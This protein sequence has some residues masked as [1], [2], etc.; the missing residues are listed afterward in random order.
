MFTWLGLI[1]LA[2]GGSAFGI[3]DQGPVVRL[4]NADFIGSINGSLSSFL[5]IPYAQPPTGSRRFRLP[6]PNDPY[7]GTFNVTSYGP[8]CPQQAS[9]FVPPDGLNPQAL[10]L[11][12]SLRVGDNGPMREDC[13]T[14]NVIKPANATSEAK[15]PVV[16]VSCMS[17]TAS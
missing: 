4:D 7:N 3:R 17:T 8:S 2:L 5:G 13:L 15:L 11:I 16:V 9:G 12:L 10:Q 6:E 14:L 1:S